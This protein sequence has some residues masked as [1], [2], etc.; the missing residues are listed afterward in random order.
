MWG[1]QGC[2]ADLKPIFSLMAQMLTH[3]GSAFWSYGRGSPGKY[4]N[5]GQT[6]NINKHV[7]SCPI[8]PACRGML[9]NAAHCG[10]KHF[11]GLGLGSLR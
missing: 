7:Q 1:G 4:G 3:F 9:R 2:S 6:K 11:K 10:G 5:N 8:L